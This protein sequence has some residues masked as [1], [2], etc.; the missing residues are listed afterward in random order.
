[1]IVTFLI[2]IDLYVLMCGGLLRKFGDF[3]KIGLCRVLGIEN[4]LLCHR[5]VGA[6]AGKVIELSLTW[7][8]Y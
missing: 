8:D 6:E 2:L 4:L 1:M 5:R 7:E 3:F